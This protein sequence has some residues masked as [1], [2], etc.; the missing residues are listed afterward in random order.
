MGNYTPG[1][2]TPRAR[3]EADAERERYRKSANGEDDARELDRLRLNEAV[4]RLENGG[5]VDINDPYSTEAWRK[6]TARRT[7]STLRMGG[8][9]H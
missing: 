6:I 8:G 3:R 7:S 2:S 1:E 9:G 5:K 4:R